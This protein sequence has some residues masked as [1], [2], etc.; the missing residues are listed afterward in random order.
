MTIT[1]AARR[2]RRAPTLTLGLG[3]LMRIN[4]DQLAF[5]AEMRARHGDAVRLRLGPYRSWLLFH[6]D[7]VETVLVHQWQSFIRFEKLTQ[8]VAQW[9][10]ANMLLAEGEAWRARRR[11]VLPAF[12]RPRLPD[13]GAKAVRHA[14]RL[15]DA[16]A[17]RAGAEGEVTIETDAAMARLTLDIAADTFF[18]S[19]PPP[20]GDVIEAAIQTLSETAFRES[21]APL[22]LPDWLPLP[23]KRRKR[24]AMGVMDAF[25][26]RLVDARL[27]EAEGDR[28]DLLSM[29]AEQ[30]AGDRT[31]IRN[32]AM[33][34]LIAG[35]E[36]SGA[37]LGWA[38]HCLVR[39]PEWR[40]RLEGE[41]AAVLHGAP[42]RPE[43]LPRLPVL[44]AVIM[45]VLR[46]YPPA[47]ALFLR[48]ATRDVAMP[49]FTI[50]KGDLVQ[51]TPYALHRD[52]R[53]FAEPERFDPAR[54]LESGAALPKA[55]LPF[56]NGPRI[57]IGQG[58]GMMEVCLV[59]ASLLQRW[60]PVAGPAEVVPEPR[61]SLRPRGGLP[62]TWQRAGRRA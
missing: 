52:P 48:R 58:F 57:C 13:Y 44:R 3:H 43:D 19:P 36:T 41:L 5:Y 31:A 12:A 37:L 14:H 53:W 49:G 2:G 4:R 1:E 33:S 27:A 30:H 22:V 23:A 21:T 9:T 45:E 26:C 59:V 25:V 16:W 34:L 6:P 7:D 39:S 60:V 38:A 50:R 18:S 47:Y 51:I 55:Y 32:D 35:H 10:G 56:G 61:F 15:C 46:L 20:D 40:A 8:V 24:R 29:L 62:I 28:G 17:A 54:F 42:P 11:K